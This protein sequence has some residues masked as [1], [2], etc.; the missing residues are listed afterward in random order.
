ME[1]VTQGFLS[2]AK[3]FAGRPARQYRWS[4]LVGLAK[5]AVGKRRL[6]EATAHLEEALEIAAAEWP[7]S[8]RLA[9]S[10]A[11]LADL[12]AALDRRNDALGLYGQAVLVLGNLPDGVNPLLAHAV[13][14]LGRLLVLK[15]EQ[16]KGQ[17]LATAA[18]ALLRKLGEPATPSIKLNLALAL[19]HAGQNSDAQLAFNDAV[20]ALERLEPGDLQGIAIHDNYALYCLSLGLPEEAETLLRRCMI[21][22]QEAGGPR[23]PIYAAGLVN[24]ARMLH[25]HD[26]SQDEAEA[27]LWQAKDIYERV[28]ATSASGMLPTLYYLARIAEQGGQAPEC[29]RLCNRMLE[30]GVG[31]ERAAAATEA[32]SLHVI[33]RLRAGIQEPDETE[34][35]MRQALALAED[36]GGGYRRL[37]VD[38]AAG[39]LEDLA[40]LMRTRQREP[41]ADQLQ[42]RADDM[43]GR[44]LW[45]VSRHV[46]MAP[47]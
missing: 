36:L 37:G 43:G 17:G 3:R 12:R 11:R 42:A 41:E 6:A 29:T 13:S 30:L 27:M 26:G 10:Y 19:A 1:A 40:A 14:N 34:M 39:L 2:S 35:Q 47:G 25:L 46:F 5:Q 24:L 18:D 33:A 22:R 44:L 20:A 21:L 9:E 45:A 23:H 38:I 7:D 4:S 8:L 31:D 28:G 32:A 15:G 16:A